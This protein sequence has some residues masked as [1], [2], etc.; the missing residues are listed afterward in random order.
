L[1]NTVKRWRKESPETA[2]VS[3]ASAFSIATPWSR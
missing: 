1:R 2:G 3:K